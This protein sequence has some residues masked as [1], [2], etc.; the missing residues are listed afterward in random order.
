M[1]R[2]QPRGSCPSEEGPGERVLLHSLLTHSLTCSTR[3]LSFHFPPSTS[4]LCHCFTGSMA[5]THSNSPPPPRPL[6]GWMVLV[7]LSWLAVQAFLSWNATLGVPPLPARGVPESDPG[8]TLTSVAVTGVTGVT[9]ARVSISDDSRSHRLLPKQNTHTLISGAD[10]SLLHPHSAPTVPV[11]TL[12]KRA[13]VFVPYTGKALPPWFGTFLFYAQF[14]SSVVDWYIFVT[15]E[16]LSDLTTPSNVHVIYMSLSELSS[17]L[18]GIDPEY[19]ISNA[20]DKQRW[21]QKFAACVQQYPYLI[22]EFKPCLGFVFQDFLTAGTYSHWGYADVDV[23]FGRSS[24]FLT[25]LVLNTF[26]I[27]TSSFGD[28]PRMYLRGQFAVFR[29]NE[30]TLNLWRKCTY[31][32]K[33][34]T[35]I[36]DALRRRPE[37]GTRG[38]RFE[39]AEGCISRAAFIGLTNLT[40][41]IASSQISDAFRAPLRDKE[42]FFVGK[43]LMRCYEGPLSLFPSQ[44]RASVDIFGKMVHSVIQLLL[45]STFLC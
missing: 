9:A 30:K 21:V 23:L 15:N 7:L 20:E 16:A 8:Q 44:E 4:S 31:F 34:T 18:L 37:G 3:C 45:I 24:N 6:Y 14:G 33:L 42:A 32:E 43:T 38:W 22:V 39:S 25:P 27:Y 26:D 41:F 12:P 13:A 36:A 2:L 5:A 40:T 10:V 19:S 1:T 11:P 28:T 29:V 35:R 17:R